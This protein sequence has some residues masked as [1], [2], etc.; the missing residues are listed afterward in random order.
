MKHIYWIIDVH[1]GC[2]FGYSFC[3]KLDSRY[4][5]YKA[6]QRKAIERARKAGLFS[7]EYD[8]GGCGLQLI[9]DDEWGEEP[10]DHAREWMKD[11]IE[12]KDE[13]DDK[14]V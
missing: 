10:D 9:Y 14:L 5:Q 6:G 11:A 1:P 4:G 8:W 7:G 12:L 2:E 13:M 3:V